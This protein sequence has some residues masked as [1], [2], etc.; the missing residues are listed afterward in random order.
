MGYLNE[1]FLVTKQQSLQERPRVKALSQ[2]GSVKSPAI[3]APLQHP[4]GTRFMWRKKHENG[5]W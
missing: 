5:L 3:S 2:E 4:K 1:I